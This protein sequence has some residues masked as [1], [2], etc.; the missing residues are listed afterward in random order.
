MIT[1]EGLTENH[2]IIEEYPESQGFGEAELKAAFTLWYSPRLLDGQTQ[3][4]PGVRYKYTFKM[5]PR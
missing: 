2:K 3:E 5:A 1:E 4:V